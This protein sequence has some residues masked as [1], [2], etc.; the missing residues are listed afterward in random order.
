MVNCGWRGDA[1]GDGGVAGMPSVPSKDGV[2]ES[3][4]TDVMRFCERPSTGGSGWDMNISDG[5]MN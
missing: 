5:N 4:T 1:V 2:V 3:A